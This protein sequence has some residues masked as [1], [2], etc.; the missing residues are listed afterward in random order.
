MINFGNAEE[1]NTFARQLNALWKLKGTDSQVRVNRSDANFTIDIDSTDVGNELHDYMSEFIWV[2]A[3][4]PALTYE[5]LQVRDWST[6]ATPYVLPDLLGVWDQWFG[7]GLA[8]V[9]WRL[10]IKVP[11][12]FRLHR[13]E[14]Y[15]VDENGLWNT[16]QAWSTQ[17]LIYPLANQAGNN[18]NLLP[19]GNFLVYPLGLYYG[20][21]A[22]GKGEQKNTNYTDDLALNYPAYQTHVFYMFGEQ[23]EAVEA[24]HKFRVILFVSN[25]ATGDPEEVVMGT[26]AN[27]PTDPATEV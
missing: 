22:Y 3:S 2:G 18:Q 27:T 7:N 23:E 13:I 11:Y 20:G 10:K 12:A 4:A 17:R 21:S 15:Q 19:G 24:A 9:C 5:D 8:D 14:M 25:P 26:I 16:G 1:Y 6:I